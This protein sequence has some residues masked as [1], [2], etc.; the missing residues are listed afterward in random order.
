MSFIKE[1]KKMMCIKDRDYKGGQMELNTKDL[2]K[3]TFLRGSENL[4][5]QMEITIKENG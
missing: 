3:I 1:K 2:G 5:I 4:Y